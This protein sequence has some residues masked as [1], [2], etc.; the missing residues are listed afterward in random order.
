VLPRRGNHNGCHIPRQACPS[1]SNPGELSKPGGALYCLVVYCCCW[2]SSC[3]LLL[4]RS[5][6]LSWRMQRL[7]CF[8]HCAGAA[9]RD[10]PP[11]EPGAAVSST[12]GELPPVARVLRTAPQLS[13]L[14]DALTTA[15]L[16]YVPGD[17]LTGEWGRQQAC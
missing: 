13:T 17:A 14:L 12:G 9:Y 6:E 16:T 10:C 4:N 8:H 3:V 1:G 11:P 7:L 2:E 15:N 5:A